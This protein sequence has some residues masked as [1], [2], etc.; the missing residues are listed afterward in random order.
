MCYGSVDSESGA[1]RYAPFGAWTNQTAGRR[2]AKQRARP[3]A[4]A[5]WFSVWR[6][7]LVV[8]FQPEVRNQVLAAQVAQSILQLHELNK[9]VVFRIETRRRLG[10]F[11]VERKPFLNALHSRP[12]R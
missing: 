2:I 5:P 3:R 1:G 6:P 10:R 7:S 11:E 9:D 8:V 12:L 4:N